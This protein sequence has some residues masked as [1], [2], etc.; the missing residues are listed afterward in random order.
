MNISCHISLST[1]Q[2]IFSL[3]ARLSRDD[4]FPNCS[5]T[6]TP[7][8]SLHCQ[9]RGKT[10]NDYAKEQ[11]HGGLEHVESLFGYNTRGTESFTR[12]R[13]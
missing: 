8:A 13:A 5:Y 6:A 3:A 11:G 10:G 7:E 9:K 4:M 2:Q 12:N 1:L